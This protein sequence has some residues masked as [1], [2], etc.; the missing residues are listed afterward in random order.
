MTLTVKPIEGLPLIKPGDDLP[1][2]IVDTIQRARLD[3]VNGDILVI[4]QK[5]VSK[6]E[7][8]IVNLTEVEPSEFAKAIAATTSDKDPRAVE[9]I[10]RETNRIVKMDRGHLI[11]ETGPGWVCAN[12]GVDES[13]NLGPDTVILLPRDPDASA[14]AI[15]RRVEEALAVNVAVIVSDTF[16]RPFREGLLDVA[17]GV[18]GMD[19]F[20]DERG[21][22]DLNGR[23]LHHTILAAADAIAGAAGLV[24]RKGAGIA[25][26]CVRGFEFTPA[27]G[28]GRR[29]VRS[30]EFDLFR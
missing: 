19:P 10:L 6:A 30:R 7:G 17:L 11:V 5:V 28:D 4:C 8:R 16:G 26:A 2:L 21:R 20:L 22:H 24:M 18:A 15:R 9:V 23:E 14:A 13:N 25:G 29:L 3:L 1:A 12:A 27:D